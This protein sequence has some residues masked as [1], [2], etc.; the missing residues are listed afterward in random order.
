MQF[1]KME[2][3]KLTQSAVSLIR[4]RWPLLAAGSIDDFNFMTVNWGMIGE[5]WYKDAMTVYVRKSRHT[6]GYMNSNDL[7]SVSILKEGYEKAL[8]IAGS[9]SGRDLDKVK[10][11]GLTP[12]EIDGVPTFEEAEYVFVLK[13]M[14]KGDLPS[15]GIEDEAIRSKAYPDGDEH[16]M[17]IAEIK[18]LYTSNSNI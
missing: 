8:S 14:F 6:F 9:K 17:Y 16:V 10:E 15:E 7:F 12:I 18:G 3:E 4:D 13:R 2:I 1:K 11:T 5:I